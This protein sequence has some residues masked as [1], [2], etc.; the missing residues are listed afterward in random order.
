MFWALNG[1]V[2]HVNC[3]IVPNSDVSGVGVR[4]ALYLQAALMIFLSFLKQSPQDILFSNISLQTTSLALICAS[5]F[6][7]NVDIP[8]TLVASEFSILFSTCRIS[9]YDLLPSSLGSRAAFKTSSRLWL[10]DIF[11]RTCLVLFNYHIWSAITKFQRDSA[12][13]PDGFG[14]WV[15][16]SITVDLKVPTLATRFA[17]TYC[18]FDLVWEGFRYVSGAARYWY[19]EGLGFT[20][21]RNQI[22]ID[23]RYWLLHQIYFHLDCRS[24]SSNDNYNNSRPYSLM[25]YYQCIRKILVWLYIVIN[26]EMTISRN[27]LTGESYWTFG[28]IFSMVNMFSLASVLLS[29]FIPSTLGWSLRNVTKRALKYHTILVGVG[30]LFVICPTLILAFYIGTKI[31][32][33]RDSLNG[34]S[35]SN[36]LCFGYIA[37]GM[38]LSIIFLLGW[39]GLI[40]ASRW[41][42]RA[43]PS[44]LWRGILGVH[45]I[46]Q[47]CYH[48]LFRPFSY[49][50]L[51]ERNV[52]HVTEYELEA[53]HKSLN[54]DLKQW[55]WIER[56]A[57]TYEDNGDLCAAAGEW[58]RI[59]DMFPHEWWPRYRLAEMF[60]RREEVDA[61]IEVWESMVINSEFI[62]PC[63]FWWESRLENAFRKSGGQDAV[64]VGWKRLVEKYPRHSGFLR[65]LTNAYEQDGDLN[66]VIRGYKLLT[67]EYPDIQEYGAELAKAYERSQDMKLAFVTWKNILEKSV[68]K[69]H[70][71]SFM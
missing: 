4:G 24:L 35:T 37:V 6:D 10:L 38:V 51:E 61:A 30:L 28:Q 23:P 58:N 11:F 16:F 70:L 40:I 13:C 57:R 26:V 66:A 49:A 3:K 44:N 8:H 29:H 59:G 69:M 7:P 12:I 50:M 20:A 18:I 52:H 55:W 1:T 62:D 34:H 36:A 32:V 47:A 71:S 46:I 15:F 68:H 60:E 5:Y 17:F 19:H 67:A 21:L 14:R 42:S 65:C 48:S 31:P 27:G 63:G 9:S 2:T 41:I 25:A 56:L 33:F 53:I 45:K 43:L 64:I 39:A 22:R 54:R